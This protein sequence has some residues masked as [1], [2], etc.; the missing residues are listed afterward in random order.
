MPVS[1]LF[2]FWGYLSPNLVS[3]RNPVSYRT[4]RGRE[5]L[6]DSPSLVSDCV[7]Q[8]ASLVYEAKSLSLLTLNLLA[9][10]TRASATCIDP[11]LLVT[12]GI[13]RMTALPPL[14]HCLL[15]YFRLILGWYR[16]CLNLAAQ[17]CF[18]TRR[19]HTL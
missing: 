15:G 1:D 9:V 3:Q 16:G 11:S 14:H 12:E 2:G 4:E 13:E 18:A 8:A 10:T 17:H 5:P 6:R 7:S 19:H